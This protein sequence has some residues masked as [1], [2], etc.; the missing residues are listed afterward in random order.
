MCNVSLSN[1]VQK[2]TSENDNMRY[3]V[4]DLQK[5]QMEGSLDNLNSDDKMKRKRKTKE[6]VKRT[7]ECVIKD[8]GKAY[9]YS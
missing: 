6:E 2:L 7:F 8:C 1:T 9:G 4:E 3:K 5:R